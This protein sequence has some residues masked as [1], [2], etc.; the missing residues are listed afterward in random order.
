MVIIFHFFCKIY[1]IKFKFE[2]FF[3]Q[4]VVQIFSK[5]KLFKLTIIHAEVNFFLILFD[6]V[7]KKKNI[8]ATNIYHVISLKLKTNFLI[9]YMYLHSEIK[10]G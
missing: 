3:T 8:M 5:L 1:S 6:R 9:N 10:L 4:K 7:G 2:F